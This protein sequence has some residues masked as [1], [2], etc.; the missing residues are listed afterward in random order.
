MPSNS[1]NWY[2]IT[3]LILNW[4]DYFGYHLWLY[5]WCL[6]SLLYAMFLAMFQTGIGFSEVSTDSN[7]VNKECFI[8]DFINFHFYSQFL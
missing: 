8:D 2:S 3:K 6:A 5:G 7:N 4:L 1:Q